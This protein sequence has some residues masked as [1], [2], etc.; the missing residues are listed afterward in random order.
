MSNGHMPANRTNV[1]SEGVVFQLLLDTYQIWRAGPATSCSSEDQGCALSTMLQLLL[2]TCSQLLRR[3][4]CFLLMDMCLLRPCSEHLW[5]S[6]QLDLCE[7]EP[8][9]NVKR[10][11]SQSQQQW[12]P[13]SLSTDPVTV[14]SSSSSKGPVSGP[15]PPD[16][17]PPGHSG[18]SDPRPRKPP[19][20][21]PP[22]LN[23]PAAPYEG[24]SGER[25]STSV[26]WETSSSPDPRFWC[27]GRS[28]VTWLNV[29]FSHVKHVSCVP[30]IALLIAKAGD[31]EWVQNGHVDTN[32]L[33][34]DEASR[35][36]PCT[37]GQNFVPCLD[38]SASQ[39]CK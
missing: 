13:L 24:P 29:S 11:L 27:A 10:Q 9:G 16:H 23:R 3:R 35:S 12:R 20:P 17:P 4:R 21:S 30:N 6:C 8:K 18:T 15:K 19:P 38:I 37:H 14:T 31:L 1:H 7:V 32:V 34:A 26:S 22:W 28:H 2:D 33:L 39:K 36:W 25:V 5:N